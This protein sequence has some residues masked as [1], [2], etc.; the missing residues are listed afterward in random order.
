[1][2]KNFRAIDWKSYLPIPICEEHP[3]YGVFY[4]TAWELARD[5]VKEI[6]GMSQNPYMDFGAFANTKKGGVCGV[7]AIFAL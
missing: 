4:E 5:H 7:V 1:M 3:E 6:D 2:N